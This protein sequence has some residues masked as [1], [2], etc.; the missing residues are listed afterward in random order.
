MR[1]AGQLVARAPPEAFII[2]AHR[3]VDLACR[4]AEFRRGESDVLPLAHLIPH[5]PLPRARLAIDEAARH[6]RLIAMDGRAAVNQH[7]LACPPRLPLA[8]SVGNGA[9]SASPS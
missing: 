5:L 2:G 6:I 4:R 7:D 8:R 3:I 1:G 9:R